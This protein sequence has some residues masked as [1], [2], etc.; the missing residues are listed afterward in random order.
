VWALLRNPQQPTALRDM[1]VV[2][3][4]PNGETIKSSL[5]SLETGIG[6]GSVKRQATIAWACDALVI[7]GAETG[8][9]HNPS[10]PKRDKLATPSTGQ[11]LAGFSL[12]RQW[13]VVLC[14][15]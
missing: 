8:C 7:G 5:F 2:A 15:R 6:F 12:R 13:M 9:A 11:I 4:V 1:V 3:L 14:N 10:C